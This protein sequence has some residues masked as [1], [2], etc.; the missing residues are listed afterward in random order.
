[1]AWP[2][3]LGIIVLSIGATRLLSMIAGDPEEQARADLEEYQRGQQ[4]KARANIAKGQTLSTQMGETVQGLTQEAYDQ[5]QAVGD[6][7]LLGMIRRK[8]EPQDTGFLKD[9]LG[10]PNG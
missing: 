10:G 7:D 3:T 8:A 5:T 6:G 2:V 1:M 9:V 4:S